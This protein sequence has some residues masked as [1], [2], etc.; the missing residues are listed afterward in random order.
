MCSGNGP[1]EPRKIKRG[2]LDVIEPHTLS[3]EPPKVQPVVKYTPYRQ[4]LHV[5]IVDSIE[6][7][8]RELSLQLINEHNTGRDFES[9]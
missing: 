3:V 9:K 6:A 5:R 2:L 4:D 1:T 8:D 7:G